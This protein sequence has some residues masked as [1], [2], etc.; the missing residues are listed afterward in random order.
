MN[1]PILLVVIA[2]LV[3][4]CSGLRQVA[5]EKMLREEGMTTAEAKALASKDRQAFDAYRAS[6][7]NLHDAQVLAARKTF[8]PANFRSSYTR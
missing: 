8:T 1:H 4:S 2:T 7:H 6:G 3:T 5:M